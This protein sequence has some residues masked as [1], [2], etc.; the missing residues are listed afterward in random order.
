MTREELIQ[1]IYE[2]KLRKELKQRVIDK[3]NDIED[4]IAIKRP[5]KFADEED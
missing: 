2:H 1:Y 5:A 4:S 3:W